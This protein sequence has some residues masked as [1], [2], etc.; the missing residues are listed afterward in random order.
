MNPSNFGISFF[1]RRRFFR[2]LYAHIEYS[3]MSY[4]LYDSM[5]KVN[6]TGFLFI[7]WRR[8][9]LPISKRASVNAEVLWDLIQDKDSPYKAV[10]PFFNVG[11][12]VGF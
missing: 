9:Q 11:I 2:K 10:Q 12:G 5:E 4:K 8:Y 3:E 7:P 1:A 6:A